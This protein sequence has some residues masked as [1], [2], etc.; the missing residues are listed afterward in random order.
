MKKKL[1][2]FLTFTLALSALFADAANGLA[3]NKESYL[4][5]L[6]APVASEYAALK[7]SP[8][9]TDMEKASLRDAEIVL[10]NFACVTDASQQLLSDF[11]TQMDLEGKAITA[12][13]YFTFVSMQSPAYFQDSA[14]ENSPAVS[15]IHDF[16]TA[17]C[18]STDWANNYGIK[19]IVFEIV[20]FSGTY[21]IDLSTGLN[22]YLFAV[23]QANGVDPDK[24]WPCYHSA[25]GG[26]IS[27]TLGRHLSSGDITASYTFDAPPA[28]V[29]V[30]MGSIYTDAQTVGPFLWD[31]V[32]LPA[33]FDISGGDY[34]CYYPLG[35]LWSEM[36]F[37]E[38]IGN[39]A[40]IFGENATITGSCLIPA[41]STNISGS[42]LVWNPTTR[43]HTCQWECNAGYNMVDSDEDGEYDSCVFDTGVCG[44][45]EETGVWHWNESCEVVC[46][47]AGEA[48]N[49]GYDFSE[50][51]T[52]T[53]NVCVSMTATAN[54]NDEVYFPA[55][56][57]NNVA[58][59]QTMVAGVGFPDQ[60][61]AEDGSFSQTWDGVNYVPLLSN[62]SWNCKDEY[63]KDGD[64]C[65]AAWP[66]GDCEKV[67]NSVW[68]PG[69]DGT[70]EYDVSYASYDSEE[71][72]YDVTPETAPECEEWK[73]RSDRDFWYNNHYWKRLM[74]AASILETGLERREIE[75]YKHKRWPRYIKR[76]ESCENRWETVTYHYVPSPHVIYTEQLYTL[77]SVF[78]LNTNY[79]LWDRVH[80]EE[81]SGSTGKTHKIR[82]A[83]PYKSFISL[84]IPYMSATTEK[85]ALSK[86]NSPSDHRASKST[87]KTSF[88]AADSDIILTDE[89]EKYEKAVYIAHK[90]IIKYTTQIKTVTCPAE[91]PSGLTIDNPH[92][93]WAAAYHDYWLTKSVC[94][95][96]SGFGRFNFDLYAELLTLAETGV[97]KEINLD[98]F[99]EK[100]VEQF[101]ALIDSD[102]VKI[103]EMSE[104][105]DVL[106]Y[107]INHIDVY[108][109]KENRVFY[110]YE[111]DREQRYIENEKKRYL[112]AEK[113]KEIKEKE[114][115]DKEIKEKEE[116][117]DIN[118]KKRVISRT[119][120]LK[121]H[122]VAA[123]KEKTVTEKERE[124][125]EQEKEIYIDEKEQIWYNGTVSYEIKDERT[126]ISGGHKWRVCN[127]EKGGNLKDRSNFKC[128]VVKE[129]H[130]GNG[131]VEPNEQCDFGAKN[132][133]DRSGCSIGCTKM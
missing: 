130:C 123:K 100:K 131:I 125:F 83:K 85:E 108:T 46:E 114:I 15:G 109:A 56:N 67:D 111:K 76:E 95:G 99:P 90:P 88:R 31:G 3:T 75:L 110:F 65:F 91:E 27:F 19:N 66:E 24:Y 12:E 60:T 55:G 38:K 79:I 82:V 37:I 2:V 84:E 132:G 41:N 50:G 36:E 87:S 25:S 17:V 93:E 115:V 80:H 35:K 119:R 21:S 26:N 47:V 11:F 89:I 4:H 102:N 57:P 104:I 78:F 105:E 70:Y 64:E 53:Y 40:M 117:R 122:T 22:W 120:S 107:V 43:T 8:V 33:A 48:V 32:T 92:E 45:E 68:N 124:L 77:Y 14:L 118:A 103:E 44:A 121:M 20:E 128:C 112:A 28:S 34:S 7:T 39:H 126:C 63:S 59:W 73:C 106:S 81:E 16:R 52:N 10:G 133:L 1:L 13:N 127:K 96:H 62:C 86:K 61:P 71:P 51:A 49:N 6:I 69:Y 23:S 30:T 9:L 116:K 54:C 42:D 74:P 129:N 5:Y 18:G 58:Y 29:V 97:I 94:E 101:M 113:E 72:V 98:L